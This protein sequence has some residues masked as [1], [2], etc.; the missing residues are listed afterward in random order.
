[1]GLVGLVGTLALL[2]IAGEGR[3]GTTAAVAS[4]GIYATVA[5]LVLQAIAA[6]GGPS[7]FG[8]ANLVTLL[9]SGIAALVTGLALEALATGTGLLSGP[10]EIGD[11]WAWAVPV[12]AVLALVLDGI[13]GWLARRGRIASAFGARFDMEADALLVLGLS[14]AVLASG[15][16]GPWIL[17]AGVLRYA[18]VAAG[19]FWP[20]LAAPLP[21]SFR[22]KAYCVAIAIIMVV[23]LVPGVPAAAAGVLA[24]AGVLAL[25]YSFAVDTVWLLRRRAPAPVTALTNT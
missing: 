21:P 5:V 1:M 15:R 3:A 20:A 10:G 2:G 24:G 25:V 8:S 19:A 23:A 13:D 17:L 6:P 12:G 16:V 7:R 22:R 11:L 18:F 14:L 9:R 4:A